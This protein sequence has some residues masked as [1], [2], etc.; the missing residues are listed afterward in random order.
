MRPN[1]PDRATRPTAHDRL[2]DCCSNLLEERYNLTLQGQ[3]EHQRLTFSEIH[4]QFTPNPEL[5][6][7]VDPW[8]NRK[9]SPRHQAAGV[10]CLQAIDVGSVAMNF[11]ADRMARA[12]DELIAIAPP[13]DDLPAGVVDFPAEW[14][15]AGC[16]FCL[17][18]G[19]CR[20][21]SLAD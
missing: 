3:T 11:F 1:T 9:A 21:P 12:M 6:W 19:Q 8:L 5:A 7:Q 13:L 17:D 2:T 16:Y 18:E 4:V 14:M 15:M 10:L 20:V